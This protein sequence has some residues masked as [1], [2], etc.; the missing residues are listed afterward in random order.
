MSNHSIL[1]SGYNTKM[2][3]TL[4]KSWQDFDQLVFHDRMVKVDEVTITY[5]LPVNQ[6]NHQLCHLDQK[7]QNQR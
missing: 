2:Q 5:R 1:Y 7:L 4:S 3:K 6:R